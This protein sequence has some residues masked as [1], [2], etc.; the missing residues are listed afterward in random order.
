MKRIAVVGGGFAGVVAAYE[1]A[2]LQREGAAVEAVLFEASPRL[3]GIVE[4]TREAG[5]TIECG[6]DGWV[7]EKP[8]ARELAEELGLADELIPSNDAT[9]KT[10]LVVDTLEGNELV[11]M[12]DGMRMMVPLDLEAL[13][14]SPLFSAEAKAAYRQEMPA[15]RNCALLPLRQMRAWPTSCAVTSGTRCWRR[16]ARRC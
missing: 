5:F 10:Y 12:P 1:L 9:R 14:R 15:P 2:K 16:W 8:W 3:G 7:S 4:T 11:A 6:P 13:D